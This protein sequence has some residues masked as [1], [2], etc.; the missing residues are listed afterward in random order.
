[1]TG[2][3]GPRVGCGAAI[4][5]GEGRILLLRRLRQPQAGCWGLPG[6]KVEAL[7]TT[8]QAM[9]REIAEE[10]G[11]NVKA[12]EFLCLVE[13]HDTTAGHFWV[14]PVYLVTSWQGTPRLMEPDRHEGP[15]WFA[16][17]SLPEQLT[18]PTRHAV[19][20]LA[21]RATLNCKK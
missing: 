20:A 15:R 13:E 9:A 21:L 19:E 6:G 2:Q 16:L 7:E 18:T 3:T 17:D 4:I 1:M 14:S 10:V 5:D 11:L 8:C 12:P